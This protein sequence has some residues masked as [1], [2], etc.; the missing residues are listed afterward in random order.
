MLN[1]VHEQS[2]QDQ[3][4]SAW[5]EDDASAKIT[6]ARAEEPFRFW[7]FPLDM[8]IREEAP[9]NTSCETRAAFERIVSTGTASK[10]TAGLPLLVIVGLDFGTS[11]TKVIVRLVSEA[12]EPTIAIPAPA[13]CRSDNHPYL[14]KA[15]L[16]VRENGEF[17]CYPE[18]DAGL[19]RTLKQNVI[20]HDTNSLADDVTQ[21]EPTVAYLAY[22]IRYVK[23]WLHCNRAN[24]LR[25]RRVNWFVNIGLPAADYD[26]RRLVNGY[27]RTAAAALVLADSAQIVSIEAARTFWQDERVKD[28]A[29]SHKSAEELGIAIVPEVAA[30][31]TPFA[32]STGSVPGLYLLVDVGAMTLDACMFRLFQKTIGENRYSL[33]SADV[34]PVGV[35]SFYWFRAQGRTEE[36]FR[37]QCERCLHNVVWY[38]KHRLYPKAEV[39]QPGNDLPVFLT[40]G[41]SLNDLHRRIV[42][43]LGPWLIS[44]TRNEGIRLIEI[45]KLALIDLPEPLDDLNRL[46]VAWGLSYPREQIGQI[47]SMS[48]IRYMGPTPRRNF[49][50]HFVSKDQV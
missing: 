13:Q 2:R 26:N 21:A 17:I 3:G 11:S 34:R 8:E 48:D 20:W 41:G 4:Q 6:N 44:H 10:E 23:G 47:K 22:V 38:V 29:M 40:G 45:P 33:W 18:M 24:L 14:W 19:L 1:T 12:G 36:E 30:A 37:K 42:E 31:A 43:D 15:V 16:W 25:G 35:E 7:D 5:F 46:V 39:F 50:N 27:R 32:K 9:R 28:A 49:A